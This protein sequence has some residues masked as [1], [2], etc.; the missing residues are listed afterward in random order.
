[1]LFVDVILINLSNE[2]IKQNLYVGWQGGNYSSYFFFGLME[3][4]WLFE[5]KSTKAK[6]VRE[7][8]LLIFIFRF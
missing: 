4:Y 3:F 6:C 1:M 5:D 7:T 8:R 2:C